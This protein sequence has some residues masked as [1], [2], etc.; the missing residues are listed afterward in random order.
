NTQ[1][2]ADINA[3]LE[4]YRKAERLRKEVFAAMPDDRDAKDELA[5]NQY[6]IAR[7]LWWAN[8]TAGAEDYFEKALAL[9]RELHRDFPGEVMYQDRL[10]VLLN[11]YAG[12]PLFNAQ[13]ERARPLLTEA[14]GLIMDLIQREPENDQFKKTYARLL[15]SLSNDKMI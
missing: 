15:R 8:D 5:Q 4:S 6:I 1:S 10:V 12:I 7:T 3:G 11:D 2:N 14:R 13:S 9:R